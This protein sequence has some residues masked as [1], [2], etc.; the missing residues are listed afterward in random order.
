VRV[1]AI[2]DIHA[3]L[4]ALEAVIAEI[5]RGGFDEIIV[6]G[7]VLPGPM[8]RE[9]IDFLRELDVSA[10]FIM[11]NGDRVVVVKM[12][13]IDTAEMP[14]SFAESLAWNAS[15]LDARDKEWIATWPATLEVE[16]DGLGS[17]LFCHASPR[18]DTEIFSRYTSESKLLPVFANASAPIV[19]CGH[20]HM[21][22]DRT[23]GGTRVVNA[24]S[25]G[26]TFGKAGAYWLELGPEIRLRR[27]EYDLASAA[28][29]IRAT[30][31]PQASEFAEN[32]V[33]RPLSEQRIL[34]AYAGAELQ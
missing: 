9:T 34:E 28:S 21:Q 19:V 30:A 8:P 17:V 1:A 22:F 24:G 26:M 20:T 13:G 18:N 27:T 25:V 16:V 31:Y 33:L 12:S 6:G 11:G 32:N 4:P 29:R 23:V 7:D 3:N 14:P 5:R 2:Y 10:R 15:Q